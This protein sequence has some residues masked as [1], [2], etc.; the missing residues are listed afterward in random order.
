MSR[1]VDKNIITEKIIL[2]PE[3]IL[4]V[5]PRNIRIWDPSLYVVDPDQ[6]LVDLGLSFCWTSG[7]AVEV[8]DQSCKGATEIEI[9]VSDT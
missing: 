2:N 3:L 7:I 6:D 4:P 1:A 8:N 9:D 5:N